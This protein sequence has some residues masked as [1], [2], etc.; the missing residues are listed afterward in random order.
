M[1]TFSHMADFSRTARPDGSPLAVC[2]ND[3]Q[4]DCGQPRERLAPICFELHC[5]FAE[6]RWG[7]EAEAL[8]PRSGLLTQSAR[9]GQLAGPAEQ[10]DD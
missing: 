4:L 5:A 1:E 6:F 9:V 3:C 10:N 2:I 7:S 8:K